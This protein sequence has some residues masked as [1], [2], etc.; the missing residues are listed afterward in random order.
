MEHHMENDWEAWVSTSYSE[1]W[2]VRIEDSSGE[3]IWYEEDHRLGNAFSFMKY[4]NVLTN[5]GLGSLGEELLNGKV[6]AVL[7]Y[8]NEVI[9]PKYG[10]KREGFEP[11]IERLQALAPD[12][13]LT[14]Y[15]TA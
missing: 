3:R 11:L 12:A 15:L 6:E 8:L 4:A 14:I 13:E 2:I 7:D 5:N 10:Y 9:E 1:T